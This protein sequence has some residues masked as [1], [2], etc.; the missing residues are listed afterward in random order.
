MRHPE[1]SNKIIKAAFTITHCFFASKKKRALK[2]FFRSE[3][4]FNSFCKQKLLKSGSLHKKL[5]LHDFIRETDK[6]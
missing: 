5:F 1:F 4:D 2:P 6:E 3:P